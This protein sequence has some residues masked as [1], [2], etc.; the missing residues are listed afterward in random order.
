M[1]SG[2]VRSSI[3][4]QNIYR[5]VILDDTHGTERR[6]QIGSLRPRVGLR[7]VDL[8]AAETVLG[9]LVANP[10]VRDRAE[11]TCSKSN[12]NYELIV[13]PS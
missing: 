3:R 7:V 8:D 9:A 2:R 6:R 12:I 1:T 4:T 13:Y 5:A 11:A 10:R